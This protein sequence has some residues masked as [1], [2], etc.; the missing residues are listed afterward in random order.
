MQNGWLIVLSLSP[1]RYLFQ[2]FFQA[3]NIRYVRENGSRWIIITK[4]RLIL[5]SWGVAF[6][7]RAQY[8]RK[9]ELLKIEMGY[10]DLMQRNP[11]TYLTRHRQRT[12]TS[13]NDKKKKLKWFN[14]NLIGWSYCATWSQNT[15]LKMPFLLC[16]IIL[17]IDKLIRSFTEQCISFFSTI[18]WVNKILSNWFVQFAYDKDIVCIPPY[19]NID[20]L[21]TYLIYSNG[22]TELW[23]II[24]FTNIVSKTWY[25]LFWVGHNNKNLQKPSSLINL[26]WVGNNNEN[27]QK[28]SSLVKSRII[29][30]L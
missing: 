29:S 28:P 27:L 5:Y 19:I 23:G 1:I 12:Q 17:Y 14:S 16:N 20:I 9:A 21:L 2:Y 11:H 22:S 25:S 10:S 13:D 30:T 18:H 4:I 3:R 15:C 24:H 7:F 6:D 26:F 8:V